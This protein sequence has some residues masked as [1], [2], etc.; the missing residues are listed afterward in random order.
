M[1]YVYD[2]VVAILG[3]KPLV[4]PTKDGK[5]VSGWSPNMFRR[6]AILTDGV[7]VEYHGFDHRT[8][9]VPFDMIKVSEDMAQGA[10]YKNPLRPLFEYKALSCLEEVFISE[11]LV[12]DKMV[13]TYL[14]TLVSTHRLRC[15]S[16][17]PS[18]LNISLL[19]SLFK[20]SNES[21][22][23]YINLVS[24]SITG[25]K[26]KK[27][28]VA[29][30]HKR[31]YLR[32][33]L[34][35]LDSTEGNLSKYFAKIESLVSSRK[36]QEGVYDIGKSF[37][38]EDNKKANFWLEVAK[39]LR[40]NNKGSRYSG[41]VSSLKSAC[42]AK[43]DSYVK[44]LKEL[45]S[46]ESSR[47]FAL[48]G[49]KVY[50]LLGYLSV[51][52]SSSPKQNQEGYLPKAESVGKLVKPE[53][54]RL[55]S[56]GENESISLIKIKKDAN[57]AD[58]LY[59]VLKVL[60]SEST[61]KV[62]D[63]SKTE[64]RSSEDGLDNLE[65]KS[66]EELDVLRNEILVALPEE[67]MRNLRS[68]LRDTTGVINKLAKLYMENLNSGPK[69]SEK[70]LERLSLPVHLDVF[71]ELNYLGGSSD[72]RG[73]AGI[74]FS[75]GLDSLCKQVTRTPKELADASWLSLDVNGKCQY[76]LERGSK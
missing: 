12:T 53:I 61:G 56:S 7:V 64:V 51:E 52:G 63:G 59:E 43:G 40:E 29:D 20:Q 76:I 65:G 15:I 28:D 68:V 75:K 37:L 57:D 6:V 2:S 60:N 69:F 30:F 36:A 46:S 33:A 18:N 74:D 9:V 71:K 16:L 48:V 62:N 26:T 54:A 21:P 55:I 8:R 5:L 23:W 42:L 49:A 44:G 11:A 35:Q 41:L 34:Y 32:P 27:I 38:Q 45:H 39:F 25:A 73:I 22:T 67:F 50:T 17:V 19:E 1:G 13:N 47:S 10:K 3:G 4:N 31:H 58:I 24:E 14:A 72:V 70:E 66:K